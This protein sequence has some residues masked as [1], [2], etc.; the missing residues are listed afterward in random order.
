MR[1]LDRLVP[2]IHT[3]IGKVA[4]SL[5]CAA[6]WLTLV[7]G[8]LGAV[9]CNQPWRIAEE[10]RAV[11]E[12][13]APL[14]DCNWRGR[15]DTW[16]SSENR[17]SFH[18]WDVNCSQN[19]P[20]LAAAVAVMYE[21]LQNGHDFRQWFHVFL[22]AQLGQ[23]VTE[24]PIPAK[25]GFFKGS[26][27]LSQ[28][29]DGWTTLAVMSVYYWS[30]K[31]APTAPY[32]AEI[33]LLADDY[34]RATFYLWGLSAGKSD[35]A[36]QYLNDVQ[37]AGANTKEKYPVLAAGPRAGG[38]RPDFLANSRSWY[39]V[40][41]AKLSSD[42][43]VKP[44]LR[45]LVEALESRWSGVYGLNATQEQYLRDL[46]LQHQLPGNLNA[47]LSGL[48]M[49]RDFHFLIWNGYRLTYLEGGT[50]NTNGGTMFAE[51]YYFHPFKPNS[52]G[53]EVHYLFPFTGSGY[54]SSGSLTVDEVGY[55]LVATGDFTAYLYVPTDRLIQHHIR[56]GPSGLTFC[57]NTLACH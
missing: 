2:G 36:V 44:S 53:R 40:K 17:W 42:P 43:W 23:T 38:A 48:K 11:V 33:K 41:A 32:A 14:E 24:Q 29:Y 12:T 16:D 22:E 30:V 15:L 8:P 51:A 20:V 46:V 28:V 35:V 50:P 21:P 9:A 37:S 39:F 57:S 47:V 5:A 34:L 49:I 18:C 45:D 54:G 6:L 25:L 31:M 55:R 27:M 19:L 4:G 56:L 7:P 13:G 1:A 3:S 26:E 10:I 52:P